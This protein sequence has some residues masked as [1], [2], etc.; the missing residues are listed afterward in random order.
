MNR[1]FTCIVVLTT[2]LAAAQDKPAAA[3]KA[4]TP[5]HKAAAAPS[6]VSTV[7]ELVKGG[8]SEGLVIKTLQKQAKPID[9]TAA[10]MLKL[11]K[12]GVSE[13]IIAVMMDPTAA[14][15]PVAV[16]KAPDESARSVQA[17]T[18]PPSE[19]A[20]VAGQATPFPP[21]FGGAPSGPVK[22]RLAVD[23]FDYSAV[24]TWVQFWFNND[25]NIGQGI[26]SMLTTRM[27]QSKNITLLE[28]EKLEKI[29]KEQDRGGTNRFAPGS[30][31]KIGKITGAD[32]MLFGDIVIFGHDDKAKKTGFGGIVIPG[33]LG[34]KVARIGTFNK[35]EK[36]VVAINLRIVDA[37]TGEFL[38]TGEARGESSRKSKDWSALAGAWNKGGAA[39]SSAMTSSNFEQTIIGEAT[40]DAVNKVVTWLDEKI[41]KMAVKTRSIE[42]RVSTISGSQMY[43]TVGAND[44]VQAGDRFEIDQIK[45][46][47]IDP[48]TKQE[49][50]KVTVKVGEFVVHSVRDKVAIGEYGGQPVSMDYK[51]GYA[52]RLMAQ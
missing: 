15:A 11:Q 35:E 34:P 50:D 48:E 18:P 22:R 26:R 44:G 25:V 13:N 46:I 17:P 2:A 21:A 31:A 10:D 30:K 4:S 8:M 19:P 14:P 43:V 29:E 9:L 42:G 51:K 28:R 27:Y 45:D 52:A 37:E 6:M 40:S 47:V 33:P 5:A 36:A 39:T 49:L 38:E 41:P 16:V 32:A 12:A 23:P 1:H 24:K 3:P 20:P 7:I